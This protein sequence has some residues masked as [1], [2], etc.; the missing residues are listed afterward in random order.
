MGCVWS[1]Q[2]VLGLVVHVFGFGERVAFDAASRQK[3]IVVFIERID[4]SNQIGC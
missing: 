1:H 3:V 4:S 2:I